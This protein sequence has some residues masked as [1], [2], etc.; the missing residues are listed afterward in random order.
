L[1]LGY[2]NGEDGKYGRV[3]GHIFQEAAKMAAAGSGTARGH[4]CRLPSQTGRPAQASVE[5]REAKRLSKARDA[6]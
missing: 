2:K 1:K 6:Q 4:G 5:Q 3:V